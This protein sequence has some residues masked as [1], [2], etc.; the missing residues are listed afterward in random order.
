MH[1]WSHYLCARASNM[2]TALQ[3]CANLSWLDTIQTLLTTKS[4]DVFQPLL[5]LWLRCKTW[6]R[7]DFAAFQL[8][9]YERCLPRSAAASL[10]WKQSTRESGKSVLNPALLP[11][12]THLIHDFRGVALGLL[13][14][15][16]FSSAK[17]IV[18]GIVKGGPAPRASMSIYVGGRR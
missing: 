14:G 16:S 2:L 3:V 11:M 13:L 1:T 4:C 10:L 9:A 18:R 15:T 8:P 6:L 12:K 7:C 5:P 17:R